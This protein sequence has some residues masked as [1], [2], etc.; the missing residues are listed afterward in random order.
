MDEKR[1]SELRTA[2]LLI[3]FRS[4]K[5]SLKSKKYVSYKRI[6]SILNLNQNEVQFICRKALMPTKPITPDKKV[7]MLNQEHY[8][9]LLNPRILE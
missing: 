8:D 9:F 2:A 4:M 3:R 1:K 7:R 6:A 5:P